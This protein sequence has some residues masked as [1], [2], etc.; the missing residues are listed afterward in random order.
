MLT[1]PITNLT[2]NWKALEGKVLDG[3]YEIEQCLSA[4]ESTASFKIRVLGDRFIDALIHVFASGVITPERLT[5]WS[6]ATHLVHP[7]IAAPLTSG[8][9]ELH[10]TWLPYIVL[11]KPEETLENVLRER[12]LTA[13]EA[14]EVLRSAIAALQF[15]H[16]RGFVHSALSP[17]TVFAVG[18]VVKLC[19][20]PVLRINT[21]NGPSAITAS[22]IAP[23]SEDANVTPAA[24][25]WCLGATI[26]ETLT[27]QQYEGDRVDAT[28]NLP[29]PLDRIIGRCLERD[30]QLR[31]TLME[32]GAMLR[33]EHVAMPAKAQAAAAAAG[34]FGAA[35]T[36]AARPVPFAVPN[37][38]KPLEVK[39]QAQRRIIGEPVPPPPPIDIPFQAVAAPRRRMAARP[40]MKV[41]IY[42][43][44]GALVVL[45]VIWLAHPKTNRG[46]P[47]PVSPQ[48]ALSVPKAPPASSAASSPAWQSHVLGPETSTAATANHV[49]PPAHQALT[50]QKVWRVVAYTFNRESDA[51]KQSQLVATKHP[52]L[53]PTVFS[54]GGRGGP[55]MVVLGAPMT[56]T[57]AV[58]FRQRARS[59]GMPRDTYIQ[60]YNQ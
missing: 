37:P 51:Q 21:A 31:P 18:D 28:R 26:L 9:C 1:E 22:Y 60:N 39:P 46:R 14:K 43:I 54:P 35:P 10:G 6:D 7:H 34:S 20:E 23:E 38:P 47:A 16:S 15:L 42:A 41:W 55:Y 5:L 27:R 25:I 40:S 59:Q 57:E 4:S 24:D 44:V 49:P 58:H 3:G 30:V 36:P 53:N 2:P 12:A 13:P 50:D 32:L 48:T 56:R 11:I 45:A 17:S 8:T 33:G 19:G 29:T 52:G